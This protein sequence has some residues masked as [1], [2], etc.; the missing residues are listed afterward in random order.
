MLFNSYSFLLFFPLVLIAVGLVPARWKNPALLLASYYFYS[1]F[2][3]RY[4]LLLL[5]CTLVVYFAAQLLRNRKWAFW[6]G[7]TILLGV[8]A[9]FKYT[10][11]ALYSLENLL[12]KL[13]ADRSLPRLNLILPMGIS[14]FT[15]Q[16]A[17]YLIDV[18]KGKYPPEEN[19][20]RFALFVSFFPQLVSGPIGR[21]DQLLPQYAA[22]EKPGFQDLRAGLLTLTWGYFLK[23]VIADR[24][25]I[26]VDTVY[27]NIEGF[28]GICLVFATMLYALQILCD[29]SGCS[30]MAIG[31]ARMLGIR[32][33]ENFN[34][35]YFAQ[36][37]QEFWR[38]W[39]ISLS[40]W[41]RDYVYFPLGGSR[42]ARWKTFRN[43]LIVFLLSG[44][45]H[46]ASWSFAV[47][48]LLH[49]LYQIV[50]KLT[51]PDREKALGALGVDTQAGGWRVLRMAGTFLLVDFAWIFFRA[52]GLGTALDMLR[53]ART[54]LRPFA[55]LEAIRLES[56]GL[57]G[58]DF[59]ALCLFLLALLGV[60]M[61]KYRRFSSQKSLAEQNWLFRELLL[62]TFML[63][64]FIFGIWGNGFDAS[65]FIYFQF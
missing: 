32:L 16:A 2:S 15:F 29:F 27:G 35:P 37:I 13:G 30:S 53:H 36:S 38:R 5:G 46:G 8:L 63:I 25:A 52:E 43:I 59:W 23:L 45:W 57:D 47:W 60:D 20:V 58:P 42:C 33:P 39:H 19:F 11:F 40:T 26:L 1:C 3:K 41:F 7:L 64:V 65:S 49:G 17:G 34:A 22:P 12:G 44:L 28:P 14:F 18:Y 48:G 55:L 24:A 56:M 50:G 62:I 10:Y 4:C 9:L 21:G 6:G 51:K 31:A 54:D 61:A